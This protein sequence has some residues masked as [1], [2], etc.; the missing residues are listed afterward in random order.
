MSFVSP[1]SWRLVLVAVPPP[2]VTWLLVEAP[3]MCLGM[4]VKV[5]TLPVIALGMGVGVGV[6]SALYILSA[7]LCCCLHLRISTSNH[8]HGRLPWIELE[9]PF[10]TLPQICSLVAR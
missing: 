2:V 8:R 10:S 7:L 6:D 1:R 4:G 3:M 5:A 9:G